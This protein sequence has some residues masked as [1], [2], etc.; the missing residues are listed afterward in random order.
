MM[1]KVSFYN[2][3]EQALRKLLTDDD[4]VDWNT[5][6]VIG[7]LYKYMDVGIS[8]C[9]FIFIIISAGLDTSHLPMLKEV[10]SQRGVNIRT[11][12]SVHLM[13]LSDSHHLLPEDEVPR[14]DPK[15]ACVF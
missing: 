4:V 1:N 11:F 15:V 8:V 5:Y 3:D 13:Y 9:I 6:F 14:Y 2:T 7:G 10:S 12:T